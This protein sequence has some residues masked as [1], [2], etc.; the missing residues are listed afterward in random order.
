MFS[1]FIKIFSRK[2]GEPPKNFFKPPSA[3]LNIFFMNHQKEKIF[4][5]FIQIFSKKRRTPEKNFSKPPSAANQ[6]F[7]L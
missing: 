7:S 4:S 1:T 6:Y 5:T 2:N 3:A